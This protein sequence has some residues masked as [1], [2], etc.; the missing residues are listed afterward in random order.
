ME[1]TNK[2]PFSRGPLPILC[3]REGARRGQVKGLGVGNNL[4]IIVEV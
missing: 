1:E 2:V 3:L 4:H